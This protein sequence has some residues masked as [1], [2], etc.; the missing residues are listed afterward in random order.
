MKK[1]IVKVQPFTLNQTAYV[2]ENGNK[3]DAV[4]T[5]FDN[6]NDV[7]LALAKE[8]NLTEVELAGATFAKWI[9]E[10]LLK[11]EYEKYEKN[12]LEIKYL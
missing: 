4:E 11:A 6:F 10:R 8:Y 3:I 12:T 2:Y 1:I 9:G 7:I 5:N